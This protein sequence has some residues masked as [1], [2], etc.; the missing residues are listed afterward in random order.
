MNDVGP[1]AGVV[2][3]LLSIWYLYDKNYCTCVICYLKYG[4][5]RK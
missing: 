5:K 4:R 3:L 2:L 1:F